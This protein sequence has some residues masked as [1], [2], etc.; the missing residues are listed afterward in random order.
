MLHPTAA[1]VEAAEPPSP[2]R[3][4]TWRRTPCPGGER[5]PPL[6]PPSRRRAPS[7][8]AEGT[9]ALASSAPDCCATLGAAARSGLN[10]PHS[11][12]AG[13]SAPEPASQRQCCLRGVLPWPAA[14]PPSAGDPAA[15]PPRRHPCS[16]ATLQPS[17]PAPTAG[18][19]LAGSRGTKTLPFAAPSRARC[20]GGPGL[21]APTAGQSPG[22]ASRAAPFP[23]QRELA[24][25]KTALAVARLRLQ[26]GYVGR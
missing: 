11:L 14:G 2:P 16:P 15:Q 9:L 1:P 12:P 19:Y 6:R 24:S 13:A 17:G 22:A 7:L 3:P 23:T 10:T 26:W 4:L 5:Q 20:P 8:S 18:R 25:A 21:R